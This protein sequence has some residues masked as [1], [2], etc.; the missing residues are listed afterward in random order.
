M[1]VWIRRA[2]RGGEPL[3]RGAWRMQLL[4]S[5]GSLS[6]GDLLHYGNG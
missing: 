6:G 4:E 1:T 5:Y 2:E 3:K